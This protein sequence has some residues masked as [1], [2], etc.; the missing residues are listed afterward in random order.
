M[1]VLDFRFDDVTLSRWR[2]SYDVTSCRKVMLSGECTSSVQPVTV[3]FCLQFLIHSTIL[4]VSK[5]NCS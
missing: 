3:E 4:L 5:V 2:S 1:T